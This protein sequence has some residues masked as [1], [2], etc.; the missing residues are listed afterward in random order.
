DNRLIF[1]NSSHHREGLTPRCQLFATWGCS[2]VQRLG[3]SPIIAIRELGL[4]CHEI[5]QSI[6][7]MDVRALRG[8]FPSI[9]EPERR[10]SGVPI[11]VPTVN[12]G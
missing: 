9:R 7:G 12:I 3:C 2:V 11:I 6:S 1:P 10:T 4:E 5:V 8:P